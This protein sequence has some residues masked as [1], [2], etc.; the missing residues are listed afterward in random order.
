MK[1]QQAFREMVAVVL[2]LLATAYGYRQMIVGES[3]INL[4]AEAAQNPDAVQ[5]MINTGLMPYFIGIGVLFFV[6]A[7]A[8]ILLDREEPLSTVLSDP[9]KKN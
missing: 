7:V 9:G 6:V 8:Y 4:S 3:N 1:L 2:V 5:V